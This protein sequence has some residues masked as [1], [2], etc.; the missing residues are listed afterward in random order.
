LVADMLAE[1]P[2]C[3]R[4]WRRR[5]VDVHEVKSRGRGG[6]ILDRSNCRAVCRECHDW[7]GNNPEQA[8]AEGWLVSQ[9]QPNE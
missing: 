2:I 6:S 7:I 9:W 8:E 1:F 4:C 5:S 3:Q